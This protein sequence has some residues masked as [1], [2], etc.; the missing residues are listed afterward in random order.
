MRTRRK[1]EP[2]TRARGLLRSRRDRMV[3][4]LGLAGEIPLLRPNGVNQ[5]FSY[6]PGFDGPVKVRT[7]DGREVVATVS[8]LVVEKG[9]TLSLADGPLTK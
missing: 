8:D 1:S 9:K 4:D 2:L 5:A 3:R 7:A 6:N